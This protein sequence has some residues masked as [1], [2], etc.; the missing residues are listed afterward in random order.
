MSKKFAVSQ[1]KDRKPMVT[2]YSTTKKRMKKWN[3]PEIKSAVNQV[4][5]AYHHVDSWNVEVVYRD[6]MLTHLIQKLS[7]K[8]K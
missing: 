8:K 2:P 3:W 5:D 4:Y 6:S 1:F 7:K